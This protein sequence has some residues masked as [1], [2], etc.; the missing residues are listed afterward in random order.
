MMSARKLEEKIEMRAAE[1]MPEI[2]CPG[3]PLRR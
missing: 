3:L 1:G 2:V